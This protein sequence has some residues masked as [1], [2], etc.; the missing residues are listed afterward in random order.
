MKP[1][2]E[3][4]INVKNQKLRSQGKRPGLGCGIHLHVELRRNKPE[5]MVAGQAETVTNP[6]KVKSIET[7]DWRQEREL[8]GRRRGPSSSF[9]AS[10]P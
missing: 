8:G 4:M 6:D 10:G 3:V 9:R 7:K 5:T 2:K 1:S